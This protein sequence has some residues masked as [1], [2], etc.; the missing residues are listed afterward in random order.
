[1]GG[2]GVLE[3]QGDDPVNPRVLSASAMSF[4]AHGIGRS[5]GRVSSDQLPALDSRSAARNV[6]R[7]TPSFAASLKPSSLAEMQAHR[8]RL[9]TILPTW[10]AP[11][12][13]R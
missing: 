12:G 13:P 4:S 7:S 11:A 9:L 10:P 6:S 2:F 3:R 8:I 5:S 1:V